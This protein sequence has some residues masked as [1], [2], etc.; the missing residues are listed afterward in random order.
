[1]RNE[2]SVE[3]GWIS[4]TTQRVSHRRAASVNEKENETQKRDENE[5]K[6]KTKTKRKRNHHS[7]RTISELFSGKLFGLTVLSSFQVFWP[8]A[9]IGYWESGGNVDM[10]TCQR[11]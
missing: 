2:C 8:L 6:K 3:R 4:S 9:G 5:E 1:M 11:S 7:I 10:A